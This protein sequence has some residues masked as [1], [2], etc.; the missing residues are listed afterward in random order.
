M[1]NFWI[2]YKLRMMRTGILLYDKKHFQSAVD[3]NKRIPTKY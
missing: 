3:N 1:V 2:G